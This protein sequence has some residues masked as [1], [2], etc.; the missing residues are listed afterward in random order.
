MTRGGTARLERRGAPRA[1]ARLE[2]AYEDV[3]RQIF[4]HAA[5]LSEDGIFLLAPDPPQT[6][7]VA[8][9]TFE[10]PGHPAILRLLGTVAR[11]VAGGPPVGFA[12]R[13]D[14]E[15]MSGDARTALRRFVASQLSHE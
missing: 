9:V 14:R 4:V 6:G 15:A 11:R 8:Q 5:D 12:V 13:F 3:D 7:V 10:L 1:A 2:A